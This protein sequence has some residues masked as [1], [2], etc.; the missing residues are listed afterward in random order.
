MKRTYAS[1]AAIAVFAL[2]ATGVW[3]HGM[4]GWGMMDEN[5]MPAMGNGRGCGYYGMRGGGMGMMCAG[6]FGALDLTQDQRT[7]INKIQDELRKQHWA[8]MGKMMDEKAKLRDL[9]EAEKPDAKKIGAVSDYLQ[10]LRKQMIESRVDAY[11]H[12]REVLTKEQREQLN[13]LPRGSWG[14]MGSGY[15]RGYGYGPMMGR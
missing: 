7:K 12:M 4:G 11:N 9:Y 2:L 15:G 13:K 14:M 8:V 3:A 5:D 1:M 6:A 10:V